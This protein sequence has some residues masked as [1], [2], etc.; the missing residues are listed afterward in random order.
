M[1][2]FTIV[3]T[4][5]E[6]FLLYCNRSSSFPILVLFPW[7]VYGVLVR[8]VG[9]AIIYYLLMSMGCIAFLSSPP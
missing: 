3:I 7:S 1:K 6:V 9:A 2:Y 8:C 5:S 4:F